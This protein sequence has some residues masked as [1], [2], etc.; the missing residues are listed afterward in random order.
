MKISEHT[1][2]AL[3]LRA[4]DKEPVI[5]I[6]VLDPNLHSNLLTHIHHIRLL[7]YSTNPSP[8]FDTIA[9]PSTQ[10]PLQCISNPRP[11]TIP[12]LLRP[13]QLRKP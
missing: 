7:H 12:Q 9:T 11:A 1:Y 2:F 4:A 13:P 8:P 5:A 10:C 3:L 6:Q